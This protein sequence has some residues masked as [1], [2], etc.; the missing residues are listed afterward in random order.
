MYKNKTIMVWFPYQ[1][2]PAKA[3][4]LQ[5]TMSLRSQMTIDVSSPFDI[6]FFRVTQGDTSG[7]TDERYPAAGLGNVPETDKPEVPVTGIIR[8]KY[9][10]TSENTV[11]QLGIKLF[12]W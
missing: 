1:P 3:P 6:V 11:I 2:R 4:T 8:E 9:Q 5:Q 10:S 7:T 12:E